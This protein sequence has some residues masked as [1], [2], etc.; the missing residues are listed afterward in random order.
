MKRETAPLPEKDRTNGLAW[1]CWEDEAW[2]QDH[3]LD[4]VLRYPDQ[5]VCVYQRQ[6]VAVHE[7]LN[8]ARTSAAAQVRGGIPTVVFAYSRAIRDGW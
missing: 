1:N 8:T 4:L 2:A 5:W 6:V 3:F 7:D